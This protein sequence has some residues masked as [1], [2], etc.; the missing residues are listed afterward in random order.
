MH[1]LN[2][3]VTFTFG[4]FFS[5]IS[6][7]SEHLVMPMLLFLCNSYLTSRTMRITHAFVPLFFSHP[8]SLS[9]I[10]APVFNRLVDR[11]SPISDL[12]FGKN[13]ST[14]LNLPRG[15]QLLR[16]HA[17]P[18]HSEVLLPLAASSYVVFFLFVFLS[19]LMTFIYIIHEQPYFG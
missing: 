8:V 7:I 14:Y 1:C 6:F 5:H 11:V 19:V 2:A 17:L 4:S 12:L 9:G 13:V 10:F 18:S 3:S 16:P 15:Y